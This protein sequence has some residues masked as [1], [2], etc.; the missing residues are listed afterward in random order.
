MRSEEE[1]KERL[2]YLLDTREKKSKKLNPG[3]LSC[4]TS[5]ID[6]YKWV[7]EDEN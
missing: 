2:Q 3:S 5:A 7:L 6:E 1:I 4:Y